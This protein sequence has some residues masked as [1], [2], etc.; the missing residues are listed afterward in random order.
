MENFEVTVTYSQAFTKAC[1]TELI[2]M[3]AVISII[4][5]I[6]CLI[7]GYSLYQDYLQTGL[8]ITTSSLF[9]VTF[10]TLIAVL[11]VWAI[12]LP[13]NL[14]HMLT[15]M[16]N[17]ILFSFTEEALIINAN[18]NTHTFKWST[19][20]RIK[21]TKNAYM[22]AKKGSGVW[23]MPKEQTTPEI[24]TF[25]LAKITEYNIPLIKG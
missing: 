18:Q 1:A 23:L 6:L 15:R 19:L 14:R 22:I 12:I 7:G 8:I 5:G 16:N 2:T 11:V 4:F 17:S 10:S 21:E 3:W 9:I 13:L 25:L 20:W 24:K